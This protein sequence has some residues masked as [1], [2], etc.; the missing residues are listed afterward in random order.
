MVLKCTV[1]VKVNLNIEGFE[2]RLH[3]MNQIVVDMREIIGKL[4]YC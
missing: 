1:I 3:W 2:A 4:F